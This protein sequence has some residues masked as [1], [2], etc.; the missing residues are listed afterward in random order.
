MHIAQFELL[1][2]INFSL[3]IVF[4]GRIDTLSSSVACDDLV[5]VSW[6]VC[7]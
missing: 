5:T 4:A 7:R 2:T 6:L 3:V 1:D